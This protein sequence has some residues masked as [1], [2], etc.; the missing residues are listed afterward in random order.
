[1]GYGQLA[2]FP[3]RPIFLTN[4]P[5]FLPTR[6]KSS[7]PK[8]L[9]TSPKMLTNSPNF[10]PTRPILL[11]NLTIF[12]SIILN[13]FGLKKYMYVINIFPKVEFIGIDNECAVTFLVQSL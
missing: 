1:M 3:T 4:S 12:L 6:P 5:N 2:Q 13:I 9:V 8:C 11:N 10:L 7:R